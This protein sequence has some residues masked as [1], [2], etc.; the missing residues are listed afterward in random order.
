MISLQLINKHFIIF[1]L[2]VLCLK[3]AN[4][5]RYFTAV[6]TC[7]YFLAIAKAHVIFVSE[8]DF[9]KK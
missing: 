6:N 5:F 3:P 4:C 2:T 7:I 9:S 1:W 8:K